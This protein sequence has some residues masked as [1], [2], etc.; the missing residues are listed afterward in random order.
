MK[1][2]TL[3]ALATVG[4]AQKA[5]V[6]TY[7]YFGKVIASTEVDYTPGEWFTAEINLGIAEWSLKELTLSAGSY[8]V[9]D[10]EFWLPTDMKHQ[11]RKWVEVGHFHDMCEWPN[12]ATDGTMYLNLENIP[13][14]RNP[15]TLALKCQATDVTFSRFKKEL[16]CPQ[17]NELTVQNNQLAN[18]TEV[19]WFTPVFEDE[20]TFMKESVAIYLFNLAD[21]FLRGM[22]PALD[23]LMVGGNAAVYQK[24]A[25]ALLKANGVIPSGPWT[26]NHKA[27][28][29]VTEEQ[30]AM[31]TEGV[32][33]YGE[34][35]YGAETLFAA[36]PLYEVFNESG[37]QGVSDEIFGSFSW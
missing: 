18:P 33:T 20:K 4:F 34:W 36:Y 8:G 29:A 10:C 24:S 6:K 1:Y 9:T 35:T 26:Q 28:H 37:V 5:T 25:E 19:F 27:G 30:I 3:A 13:Q 31:M 17:G 16:D 21:I 2:A 11:Q 22:N 14:L 7:D 32:I 15:T 23:L 12:L